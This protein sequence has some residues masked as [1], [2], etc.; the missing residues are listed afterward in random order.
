MKT[1]TLPCQRDIQINAE[2]L[3]VTLKGDELHFSYLGD[4]SKPVS[5]RFILARSLLEMDAN[6]LVVGDGFQMLAQTAGT[7]SHPLDIGRCPDNSP[8]YRIY[9]PQANKRYYHYLVIEDKDQYHLFGFT[10]C[11]RF[12]GYFEIVTEQ[13][14]RY[15]MAAIDGEQTIPSQW[16]EQALESLV[17]LQAPSLEAVYQQ[18]ADYICLHHSPRDGVTQKA[19]IGWCSWYAYY[20]EVTERDIQSNLMAMQG[21][22]A[23]LEWVL[24]DDGYQAFMGDWLTPSDKFSGGVKALID[25][26]KAAGKKPAIWLAPFIAQPESRLFQQHPDWFVKNQQGQPLKAEEITYGGWRCTPWYL[27]DGSHPDAQAYL[28]QVV[29]TM[30]EEWGIELFKLDANYW[31]TLKG[32]RYQSGV[33]GVEA[34]RMGM[35]AIAHGAGDAWLLGCNA[36]MWPSLGLVDAMRVSD[37]VERHRGRFGQIA[38]ETFYRSWQHRRLWQIDPDCAT[39]VSLPDQATDNASYQFHRD[40]LLTCGGLLLSGDPLFKLDAFATQSLK[41]LISRQALTQSAASFQ[42]L[43]MNYARLALSANQ[44]LHCG[45]NFTDQPITLTLKQEQPAQ[46][47]DYW[48]GELLAQAATEVELSLTCAFTSRVIVSIVATDE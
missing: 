48:T 35:Q 17:I 16:R 25:K 43:S 7:I 45:F 37:D 36:P 26:I 12:A 6:A 21:E 29:R 38:Q 8:S 31:G 15:L 4:P 28:R 1:L 33:T 11:H 46:W 20:A 3:N 2:E 44:Q 30:R 22:L 40:V 18:Y 14:N 19:P 41:Q 27:L 5:E 39:L 42:S 13:Q 47:Y 9:S 23:D 10:S 32:Q 24:L 34:Y